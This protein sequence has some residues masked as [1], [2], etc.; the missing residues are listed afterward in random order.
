MRYDGLHYIVDAIAD[1]DRLNDT[2]LTL[3]YVNDLI[4]SLDMTLIVAPQC[5]AFPMAITEMHR[6][7][8]SLE[9]EGLGGS[10]TAASLRKSLKYRSEGVYGHTCIAVIAESHIAIHTFPESGLLQFDVS[11][12]KSFPVDK[13][14]TLL[15]D[16]Y[17]I[18]KIREHVI[19]RDLDELLAM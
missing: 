3:K 15:Y 13:V 10:L 11:S 14:R 16:T 2:N 18:T 5:I 12:C 6:S 19:S 4:M 7:L 1:S 17:G 8:E 9:K